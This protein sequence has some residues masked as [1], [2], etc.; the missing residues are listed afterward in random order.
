MT[1]PL[2]TLTAQ[3]LDGCRIIND[4]DN[5]IVLCVDDDVILVGLPDGTIAERIA[6]ACDPHDYIRAWLG[7]RGVLFPWAKYAHCF[8]DRVC[9]ELSPTEN[10][11]EEEKETCPHCPPALAAAMGKGVWKRTENGWEMV[12]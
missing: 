8:G 1:R 6:I 5:E 12:A 11:T 10:F 4:S 9:F 2:I 7:P 3:D